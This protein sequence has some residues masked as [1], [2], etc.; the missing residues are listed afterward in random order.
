MTPFWVGLEDALADLDD[1][2]VCRL[3]RCGRLHGRLGLQPSGAIADELLGAVL[4]GKTAPFHGHDRLSWLLSKAPRL[5]LSGYCFQLRS[6]SGI[7]LL[8]PGD[9]LMQL[10]DRFAA[11]QCE[12]GGCA[13]EETTHRIYDVLATAQHNS[14]GQKQLLYSADLIYKTNTA[15]SGWRAIH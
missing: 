3:R 6:Q 1:S 7:L 10:R 5:S 8:Q 13:N 11:G 14:F 4:I 15:G 12:G 2:A 9:D